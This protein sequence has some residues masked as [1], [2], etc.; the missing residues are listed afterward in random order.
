MNVPKEHLEVSKN[1]DWKP[2]MICG[3]R[4]IQVRKAL[5][6]CEQ[7]NQEYVSIEEDMRKESFWDEDYEE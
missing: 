2:C 4:I 6:T 3:G 5:F 7:C 1:Q